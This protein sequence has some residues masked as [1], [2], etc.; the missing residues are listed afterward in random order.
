MKAGLF[1]NAF[2]LEAL[3]R[4][5]ALCP[6]TSLYTSDE[7]IAPPSS[8]TIIEAEAKDARAV[9]NAEP[10]R[11]SGNLVSRRRVRPR[12][13]R[14]RACRRGADAPGRCRVRQGGPPPIGAARA[15][16]SS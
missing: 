15:M 4:F 5:S 13:S 8:R 16:T 2:V 7:E 6:L 10:G 3:R 12:C 1:M 9:F 14:A 11:P